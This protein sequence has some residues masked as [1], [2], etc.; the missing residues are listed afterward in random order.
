MS[1]SGNF[2][3]MK[4]QKESPSFNPVSTIAAGSLRFIIIGAKRAGHSER[5]IK[6]EANYQKSI[7]LI[8]SFIAPH[9]ATRKS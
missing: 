5:I 1:N 3:S 8:S 6:Q 2:D 9:T 7:K 4:G